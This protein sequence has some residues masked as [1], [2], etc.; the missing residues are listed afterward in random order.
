MKTPLQLLRSEAQRVKAMPIQKV[1]DDHEWQVLR[2]KLVGHWVRNHQH[3]V[4]LLK[5][6][7]DKY[8]MCPS[9][10]RRVLNVMTGSVHRAGHTKGQA[11][12]DALRLEVRLRWQFML[13]VPYDPDTKGGV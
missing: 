13:G 8:P 3:N 9:A 5:A 6:Y 12:T 4:D 1:V 7:L 10:C 11:S 2:R